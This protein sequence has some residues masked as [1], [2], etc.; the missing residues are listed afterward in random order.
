[1]E[2]EKFTR[3]DN[4]EYRGMVLEYLGRKPGETTGVVFVDP[5]K[6][7]QLMENVGRHGIANNVELAKKWLERMMRSGN[8]QFYVFD[9]SQIS[10]LGGQIIEQMKALHDKSQAP[11]NKGGVVFVDINP[12]LEKLMQERRQQNIFKS[13]STKK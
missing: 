7:F 4:V 5:V 12:N 13:V 2:L 9:M 1:M 8:L 6:Q 10:F 3:S 11:G